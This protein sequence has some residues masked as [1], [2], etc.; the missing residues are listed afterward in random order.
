M[1]CE[2]PDGLYTK[3]RKSARERKLTNE[4]LA[5]FDGPQGLNSASGNFPRKSQRSGWSEEV[6]GVRWNRDSRCDPLSSQYASQSK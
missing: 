5:S 4:R 1:P 3:K 6:I 2:R